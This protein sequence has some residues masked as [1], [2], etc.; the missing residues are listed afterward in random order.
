MKRPVIFLLL[1]VAGLMPMQAAQAFDEEDY[2]EILVYMRIQGIGAFEMPA[3]FS[4][5][6]NRLYLPVVDLFL[7]LRI[8]Q[9]ATPYYDRLTGFLIDEKRLYV[10]DHASRT[11]QIDGKT[12]VLGEDE[13]LR[14]ETGLYLYTGVFGPVFG[15]HCT[16]HFRSL[17]V[18]LKTDLELPAIREMRLAMM[19]QNVERLRGEV[20][21]D[22]TLHRRYHFF[23]FGMVDW[24]LSSTQITRSTTDTRASLGLGSEFLFGETN[25]FLNYSSRDGFNERNQHYSWRWANN[26]IK[27]VRQVRAGKIGTGAISSI[28]NPF[29]GVSATNAPTTFRRSYGE[30]TLSDFT[31]PG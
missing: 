10:I 7:F 9:E 5:S 26:Q 6:N 31:E 8:N 23:R 27:P 2:E 14:T 21:V 4:Y 17:S 24:A 16:F 18:E 25:V 19:R 28:Y 11:I 22:T 1:I 3:Y 20:D 30:Y 15:L 29:I 12:I 13:I